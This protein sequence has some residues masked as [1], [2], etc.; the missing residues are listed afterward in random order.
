MAAESTSALERLVPI[1]GRLRLY[2]RVWLRPDLLAGITLWAVLVPE[3]MAYAGIAG[4]PPIVGLYTVPLPLLAYAIFGTSRIMVVGPDSATA[5]LS[6][7]TVATLAT[8]ETGDFITLTAALAVLVGGLFLLFGLLRLGW[9]ADFVSQ[10]VMQGFITGVVLVTIV[11]QVPPLLG[12][13]IDGGD[14]FDKI[15]QIARALDS[16]VP[17]TVVVGLG[18]LVML[19]A[20]HA[21]PR[22]VPAAL[23]T[24]T[25]AIIAGTVFHLGDRG[26]ALVG[27]APSGLPHLALPQVADLSVLSTLLPG[28]LAIVLLGYAETLGSAKAAAAKTGGRID[29]NQEM[30]ALGFANIGS[31]LS[32]GFV[33]VGSF[34]KTSVAVATGAKTQLGYLFTAVLV[35]L[36]LMFLMP[37]FTNLPLAALAAVVIQAMFSLAQPS[38]FTR[39][40]RISRAEFALAMVSM[41]GVLSLGVLP[42][43]GAGVALSL[44]LLIYSASRPAYAVIGK[45]AS[46]VFQDVSLHPEAKT[47][48][49]LLI[50]RFEGP[51]I[52][53]NASYF[54]S[55]LRRLVNGGDV[56][57][58][59]LDAEGV[60][61]I[62]ST[63]V[64]HLADLLGHLQRRG[65]GLCLARVRDPVK[66]FLRR[67]GVFDAIGEENFFGSITK[68]VKAYR[69]RYEDED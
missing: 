60:N 33:A 14:F 54:E 58:V 3:A 67:A 52:F 32:G 21:L 50:F 10:P 39:L 5:L 41:L 2:R 46:H 55:E 16:A 44:I 35:G 34:S 40:W 18:S 25:L 29:P 12:I 8:P 28:A 42:G 22:R 45:T 37:V 48:P 4:V 38:Y 13:E 26:V 17:A 31:G 53:S 23:I 24:V 49:G 66:D 11:V 1:T 51:L 64:S 43:I 6:A 15:V 69:K 61:H 7:A 57:C 36:T 65:I 63:A 9:V 20:L 59:L 30:V 56:H 68:A 47:I 19:I 27:R 62:D